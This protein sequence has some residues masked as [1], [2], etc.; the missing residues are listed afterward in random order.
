MKRLSDIDLLLLVLLLISMSIAAACRVK[1]PGQSISKNRSCFF[2]T[3]V[4]SDKEA[5]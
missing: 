2:I 3:M 4:F 5:Q 1:A